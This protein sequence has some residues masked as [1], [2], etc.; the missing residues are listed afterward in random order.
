[1]EV[2]WAPAQIA[3]KPESL[4]NLIDRFPRID[5]REAVNRAAKLRMRS[6][7]LSGGYVD[8]DADNRAFPT[9]RGLQPVSIAEIVPPS[10]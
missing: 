10:G 9:P 1:M 6:V 8:S 5:T 2:W 3:E 4:R 7:S